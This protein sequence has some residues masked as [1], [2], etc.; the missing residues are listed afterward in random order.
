MTER[1]VPKGRKLPASDMKARGIAADEAPLVEILMKLETDI[2][3]G[4]GM[5]VQD[6]HRVADQILRKLKGMGYA[7]VKVDETG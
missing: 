4:L 6:A 5:P 7:V 2:P 1:E 3:V